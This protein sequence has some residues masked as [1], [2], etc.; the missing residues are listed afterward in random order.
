MPDIAFS[1][2]VS[3]LCNT[4]VLHIFRI[5]ETWGSGIVEISLS[6][7]DIG[8][9]SGIVV[10]TVAVAYIIYKWFTSKNEQILVEKKKR[11][12]ADIELELRVKPTVEEKRPYHPVDCDE[13]CY[14]SYELF[15]AYINANPYIIIIT[16]CVAVSVIIY[17]METIIRFFKKCWQSFLQYWTNV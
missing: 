14:T 13:P 3:I 4:T 9:L 16:T 5:L 17:N 12:E 11:K 1:N 8:V 7:G 6:K 2:L 10:G 15:V